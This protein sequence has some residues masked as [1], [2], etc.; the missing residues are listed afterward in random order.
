M[1]TQ[2]Y[3]EIVILGTKNLE[4]LGLPYRRKFQTLSS[5]ALHPRLPTQLMSLLLV[6][7]LLL[8]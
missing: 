2:F 4:D 3:T 5:I 7:R 1:Q 8:G 6:L